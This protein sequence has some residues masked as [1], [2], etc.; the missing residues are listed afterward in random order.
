MEME[1]LGG[2]KE[3]TRLDQTCIL[4]FHSDEQF[5]V[6]PANRTRNRP[7]ILREKHEPILIQR[8]LAYLQSGLLR[9]AAC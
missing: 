4:V 1:T 6:V 5:S 9:I 8:V 3:S 2:R 7:Y